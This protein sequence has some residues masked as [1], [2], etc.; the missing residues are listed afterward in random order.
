M[1]FNNWSL[2]QKITSLVIVLLLFGAMSTY[3]SIHSLK[4]IHSII[5]DL[6]NINYETRGLSYQIL[7]KQRMMVILSR[8]LIIEENL[9]EIP[10]IDKNFYAALEEQ[11]VF[12]KKM[13]TV[14]GSD[15]KPE[16]DQYKEAREKWLLKIK[17]SFELKYKNKSEE[18]KSVLFAAQQAYLNGMLQNLDR[19]AKDASSD[20]KLATL[21]A[22]KRVGATVTITIVLGTISALVAGV[23]AFFVIRNLKK[24]INNIVATLNENAKQVASASQQ[25]ASSSEE[26]SHATTEQ[27]ASLEETASSIEEMS[28]MVA[29]NSDNSIRTATT[30]NE[31]QAKAEQGKEVVT[32][33][34]SAMEDINRSNNSI[35]E[36]VNHGN[37]QISEIVKVIQEIGNKTKVINDIVFQT[38]LLSFNASVEAARAGEQGKGFAVVAEEVGNLAQMSGNAAKEITD[39]LENSIRK[40]EGIVIET[41]TKVE[42]EVVTGKEKVSIG[43]DI[44][45][46][47]GEVLSEIVRDVTSVSRMAEEIS[48][49][50][51]EQALGVAEI[52]KAISQLDTVTQQ[53]A[54][55]SEEAASSAEELSAQADSLKNAVFQ[56]VETIEGTQDGKVEKI[57]KKEEVKK[58]KSKV[59]ETK[60]AKKEI[61]PKTQSLKT[62]Y[63]AVSGDALVPSH[64]HVGF[65]DV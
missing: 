18:V 15:M 9:K 49:A 39:L 37:Q 31:S 23:I 47:C 14:I 16:L 44:A 45:N 52:T 5:N 54:A 59:L 21:E 43:T 17:E 22:E 26:L 13:D 42:R 36:Q 62:S 61:A 25:I 58:N 4:E 12:L 2:Y 65:E 46:K 55:T 57:V 35:V 50:S 19:I 28:S 1:K 32:K 3:Y 33:M 40:V 38:K 7:D 53:N 8:N 48:V 64:S 20:A 11:N 41:K 63:K 34:I 56:L 6:A 10:N 30:S 60:I 29:R 51:K 27:A 24:A